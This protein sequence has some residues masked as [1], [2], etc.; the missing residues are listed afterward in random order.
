MVFIGWLYVVD[1]LLLVLDLVLVLMLQR[2]SSGT[3]KSV[4]LS[5]D[6]RLPT[7]VLALWGRLLRPR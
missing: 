7:A 2:G 5:S 3:G 6:R 4:R 1:A